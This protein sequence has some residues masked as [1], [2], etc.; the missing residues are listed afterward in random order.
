M[1]SS[2]PVQSLRGTWTSSTRPSLARQSVLSSHLLVVS[3]C[4]HRCPAPHSLPS[5]C[6]PSAERLRLSCSVRT[7][8][9]S[10]AAT[11]QTGQ[12]SVGAVGCP[13]C[14]S[15][16]PAGNLACVRPCL[17]GEAASYGYGMTWRGMAWHG[18]ACTT[19]SCV[20]S[21]TDPRYVADSCVSL[22]G[23]HAV[24]LDSHQMLYSAHSL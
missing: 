21:N 20:R 12:R 5:C 24:R 15:G 10:S 22:V 17:V 1:S 16:A 11:G 7:L 4:L 13:S 19:L 2:A 6:W 8:L 3:R 23:R 14:P 9:L 18:M